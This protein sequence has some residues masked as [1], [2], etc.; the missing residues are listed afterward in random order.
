MKMMIKLKLVNIIANSGD[1]KF[2]Q[3][4]FYTRSKPLICHK[5][6]FS[7][8]HFA[9]NTFFV[10]MPAGAAKEKLAI[11]KLK[12]IENPSGFSQ[13][14]LDTETI[15]ITEKLVFEIY[16]RMES[17]LTRTVKDEI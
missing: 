5:I 2:K 16:L 13:L 3:V 17:H 4:T 6:H 9:T 7:K 14:T 11:G 12:K 15:N 10:K 8:V 1:R